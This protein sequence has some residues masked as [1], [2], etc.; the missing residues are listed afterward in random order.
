MVEHGPATVPAPGADRRRVDPALP[1]R[2]RP[3]GHDDLVLDEAALSPDPEVV[4]RR[5]A[6][7]EASFGEVMALGPAVTLVA[8]THD[9]LVVPMPP[10]VPVTTQRV[11]EGTGSLVQTIVPDDLMQVVDAWARC[12]QAGT[13][14]TSARM[15]T[16]P[17][18]PLEFV[19][20]DL[21]HLY[22]VIVVA[23]VGA[24]AP[25]AVTAAPAAVA[26]RPRVGQMRMN[27][28]G[29]VLDIEPA[30]LQMLG[31]RDE[32]VRGRRLIHLIHPDDQERAVTSWVDLMANPGTTRRVRLRYARDD[33]TWTWCEGT[34]HNLLTDP[35]HGYVVG[36]LVD[37][38]EE[39]STLQ[40][41]EANEELL[42]RLLHALPVAVAQTDATGRVQVANPAMARLLGAVPTHLDDVLAAVPDRLHLVAELETVR[43]HKHEV[44]LEVD[45]AT[46]SG[47]L[48][49]L[50]VT[51]EPVTT[52]DGTGLL[53]CLDDVTEATRLRD[54]LARRATVDTLTGCLTR[55]AFLERAHAV[56][57]R[58]GSREP[59]VFFLDLD[60]FKQVNDGLGHAAGDNLLVAV[61]GRLSGWAGGGDLVGRLGGDE[62]VLLTCREGVDDAW[63][64]READRLRTLV[65]TGV[66]WKGQILRPSASVGVAHG[67]GRGVD[68]LLAEADQAM[69]RDKRTARGGEYEL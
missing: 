50:A 22:G 66:F 36:E 46:P 43:A 37:V 42:R 35:D 2:P 18:V 17:T 64:A 58:C 6:A 41:L 57:G 55:G 67:R 26:L 62:F 32:Q 63:A 4:A 3:S 44:R 52:S 28:L 29:A 10:Q 49:R 9:G 8:E 30:T 45:L 54:E 19:I 34:N 53:L 1:P 69:Y 5:R 24:V 12:Q 25:D 40:A 27:H 56:L 60:E 61:G 21:R 31:W 38:S 15:V 14:R 13:A 39:M 51:L 20:M 33:G 65:S 23:I 16:S 48:R 68:D 11:V 7:A 47:A 59:Y